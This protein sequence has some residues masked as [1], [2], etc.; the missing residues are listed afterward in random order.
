MRS[1]ISHLG[2]RGGGGEAE[3]FLCSG[4]DDL[5]GEGDSFLA[6]LPD[7]CVEVRFLMPFSASSMPP[8]QGRSPAA[9]LGFSMGAMR[10]PMRRGGQ[11]GLS[12]D[13]AG[14]FFLAE[15]CTL[16]LLRP[17]EVAILIFR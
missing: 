3:G 10:T 7:A 2:T 4:A 13:V 17:K 11:S 9:E 1:R 16:L 15:V 8:Q 14:G 5:V 6:P 12:I